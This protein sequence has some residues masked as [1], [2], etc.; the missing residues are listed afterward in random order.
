MSERRVRPRLGWVRCGGAHGAAHARE[1]LAHSLADSG[2]IS[3]GEVRAR[4]VA[5]GTAADLVDHAVR[6]DIVARAAA[7]FE[8]T[9][10][11][12]QR[13]PAFHEPSP[14]FVGDP[15]MRDGKN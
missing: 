14:G 15:A 1:T 12:M 4:L 8:F 7:Q 3:L 9:L 2:S 10:Q 11:A 5:A 6:A 13:S